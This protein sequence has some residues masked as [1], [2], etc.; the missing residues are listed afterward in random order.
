[1]RY[2]SILALFLISSISIKAQNALSILDKS[3]AYHDP[4]QHWKSF[5]GK[6]MI[7]LIMP[8][9]SLRNSQISIDLPNE[10]FEMEEVKGSNVIN[11]KI[12]QSGCALKLNGSDDFTEEQIKEYRLTCD[13]AE[14]YKNYYTFLYGLPMKMK[15]AGAIVHD[16]AE[17]VIF[18]SKEYFKL[19]ITF[20]EKTGSDTWYLY[21]NPKNYAMEIYQFYHDE[22][23]NDGEYILLSQEVEYEGMKIPKVRKW[24]TNKEDKYLGTDD[25]KAIQKFIK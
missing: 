13:R 16:T 3:I 25:L 8:D 1:M 6:L 20:D 12:D 21:I 4:A 5:Q 14:M 22:T 17:K 24:Y 9:S 18:K 15:D 2:L 7:D 11:R 10:I 23:K 19:K